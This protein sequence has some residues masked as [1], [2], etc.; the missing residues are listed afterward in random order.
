MIGCL[1][2][3]GGVPQHHSSTPSQPSI[4]MGTMIDDDSSIEG[5]S[6]SNDNPNDGHKSDDSSESSELLGFNLSLLPTSSVFGAN[7]MFQK[8]QGEFLCGYA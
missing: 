5:L 7:P 1:D 6:I 8:L 2:A 4:Q 3:D